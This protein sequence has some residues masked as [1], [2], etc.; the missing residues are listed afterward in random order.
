MLPIFWVQA[1]S[2]SFLLKKRN[3]VFKRLLLSVGEI[4]EK[5]KYTKKQQVN[6]KLQELQEVSINQQLNA[7]SYQV[8]T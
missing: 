5:E 6:M 7:D 3:R 2:R 4:K 8:L 1:G